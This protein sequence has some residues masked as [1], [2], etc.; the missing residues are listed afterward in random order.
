MIKDDKGLFSFPDFKIDD[1]H[2]VE[3]IYKEILHTTHKIVRRIKKV[4]EILFH[5]NFTDYFFVVLLDSNRWKQMFFDKT[6]FQIRQ[7]VDNKQI[8]NDGIDVNVITR[9]FLNLNWG[10]FSP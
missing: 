3:K 1:Y 10:V 9:E 8:I 7:W 4:D 5:Y 2:N 6:L